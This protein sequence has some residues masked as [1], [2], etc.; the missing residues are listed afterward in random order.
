MDQLWKWV[1]HLNAKAFCLAAALG[2]FLVAT[3]CGWRMAYA[4][5]PPQDGGGSSHPELRPAWEIGTLDFVSNQLAEETLTLPTDPFRPTIEAIFTNETERV[6]FLRA[7]KAAQNAAAGVAGSSAGNKKE[8]PFAHL[9]SSKK[10]GVPGGLTGPDGKPMVIPKLQFK[11]FLKRPDGTQ[12][13]MFFDSVA[14]ST[15]FYDVGKQVHGVDILGADGREAEIRFKNGT[16]RKLTIDAEPIDLDSEP[17]K[18]PPPKKAALAKA[19][20]AAAAAAK[21]GAKP[22]AEK[23]V[24]KPGAAKPGAAKPGAAQRPKKPQP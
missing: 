13:A 5:T 9:R 4:P 16:T 1:M 2:F 7:L 19:V 6:A 11:G 12:T 17:A 8:D 21:A 23:P 18:T 24:V 15:V 14:N 10:D 22:G 20:A 3:Y